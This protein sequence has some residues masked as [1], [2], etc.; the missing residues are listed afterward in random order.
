MKKL[1]SYLI[2]LFCCGCSD[3][4]REDG[5]TLFEGDAMTMHYRIIVEKSDGVADIIAMTFDEVNR[6]YNKWNPSSELSKLNRLKKGEKAS[7]S[8]DL[9]KLLAIADKVVKA[10][11]GR[12]DPTIEPAQQLWKAKLSR[13]EIPTDHEVAEVKKIVGWHHIH[14]DEGV[15]F[16][17]HD[18]TSL[19]LGG[20]AKGYAVDL[21]AE[22]IAMMSPDVFVEWGGEVRTEGRH[23]SG[24]PWTVYICGLRD[25]DPD[26]AL[27][28][29]E[30]E[31]SSLAT[32]GD[33]LQNTQVDGITYFHIIDPRTCRP[34]VMTPTSIASASVKARTC[35]E[36]DGLAT[37][38]M[39]FPS[40][41]AAA[42]WFEG[43]AYTTL[44][45][46]SR[47]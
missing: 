32:S 1:I 19:D 37:A 26:N 24:R 36:A 11:E 16:K 34:L 31:G 18:G 7:L 33:Y 5:T 10:T 12:F 46:F 22:R 14:F 25:T 29:L 3:V 2:L 38:A 28:T 15:F 6:V 35:A 4:Q 47:K 44:W 45:A 21:L 41:E 27:A 13:G 39:L 40:K 23:P 20:I 43:R 9:Y 42:Q 17:D 30:L 8:P